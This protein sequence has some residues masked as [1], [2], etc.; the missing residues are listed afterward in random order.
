[1]VL[2]VSLPILKSCRDPFTTYNDERGFVV[3]ERTLR[4]ASVLHLEKDEDPDDASMPVDEAFAEKRD[5]EA[6]LEISIEQCRAWTL[7]N[8]LDLQVA[9]IDPKIADTTI[10]EE[11][12]R[13]E[14]VFLADISGADADPGE[15]VVFRDQFV[16]PFTLEP[17]VEIPLRSGGTVGVSL[18]VSR[19]E[20][21]GGSSADRFTSNLDLSISHPLLRNA[22][23]RAN[24]H[25]IRIATLDAQIARARTKLEVIRQIANADRAYWLLYEARE[26]LEIRLRQFAQALVQRDRA[27]A[28]FTGRIGPE[29]DVVRAEAGVSRRR[30]SIIISE[31]LVRDRQRLLKRVMNR[32]GLDVDSDVRLKPTTDPASTRYRLKIDALV[33]A[34]LEERMELLEIELQLAQDVSEIEYAENQT[35]PV[36]TLDYTYR[37]SGRGDSLGRSLEGAGKLDQWGWTL[38][39]GVEIPIGNEAARS[40]LQRAIFT[41]LQ[42][43]ATKS[44]REQ[45]IKQEVLGA[46]D[47]LEATWERLVVAIQNVE[48]EKRNY[49]GEFGQFELGLRN[50][51]DV[52][53]AEMLWADA[54]IRQ[55]E[56]RVDYE[57]AQVDIAFATGML[58]GASRVSW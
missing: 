11:E 2:V 17:G 47:N 32:P 25:F 33:Q 42:R 36:V 30:A 8:N 37:L 41:R 38:G 19:N 46:L 15:A 31:L 14:S 1:M 55:L 28:R 10:K 44:A 23:R 35:L 29:I 50:S 56:A 45:V 57:I 18:P 24:T 53:E 34:A 5:D 27:H 49:E 43:L 54:E 9:M 4:S 16:R 3:D 7:A 52:L 21:F 6:P 12:A 13:F 20:D 22:G 39:L 48:L 40:R 58:L 26:R 51:T